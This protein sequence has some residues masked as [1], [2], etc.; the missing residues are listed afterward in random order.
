MNMNTE[1]KAYMLSF[2]DV[3]KILN[4]W[5]KNIKNISFQSLFIFILSIDHHF[6]QKNMKISKKYSKIVHQ[7][8]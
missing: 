3:L 8:H 4:I 2:I 1:K 5:Y 7:S 6:K